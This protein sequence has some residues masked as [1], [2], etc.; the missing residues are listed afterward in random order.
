MNKVQIKIDR[1][2]LSLLIVMLSEHKTGP[3]YYCNKMI[4]L[5]NMREAFNNSK[6]K[7]IV[8]AYRVC[9]F[10]E[11]TMRNEISKF[12]YTRLEEK[13]FHMGAATLLLHTGQKFYKSESSDINWYSESEIVLD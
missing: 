3:D 13:D 4:A 12:Y 5:S 9:Y 8:K 2:I 11:T 10:D 7:E 1:N 6:P